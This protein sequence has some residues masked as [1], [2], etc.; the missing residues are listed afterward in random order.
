MKRHGGFFIANIVLGIILAIIVLFDV[1][2]AVIFKEAFDVVADNYYEIYD[3][4]IDLDNYYDDD[5]YDYF[6]DDYYNEWYELLSMD[7]TEVEPLGTTYNG[8]TAQE[9]YQYYKVNISFSNGGTNYYKVEYLNIGFQGEEY[10][11][12]NELQDIT[13][14]L[15]VLDYYND[16]IIP[17]GQSAVVSEIIEVRDGVEQVE[18]SFYNENDEKELYTIELQ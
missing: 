13:G 11:D 12:V 2:I 9:G 10:D 14:E 16:E 18:M 7:H 1:M 8:T 4:A 5:Y 15:S 6:Y 3:S 17:A